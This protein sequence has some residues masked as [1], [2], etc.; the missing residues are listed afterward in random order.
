[1]KP[2]PAI[3]AINLPGL[4]KQGPQPRYKFT[5]KT[6]CECVLLRRPPRQSNLRAMATLDGSSRIPSDCLTQ[7]GPSTRQAGV[8]AMETVISARARSVA[9]N[10]RSRRLTTGPLR[11]LQSSGRGGRLSAD[12]AHRQ[13][14]ECP[15]YCRQ[16][17]RTS[18]GGC[19]AWSRAR[20]SV[21]VQCPQYHP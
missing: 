6:G 15:P 13:Q 9:R 8:S 16:R 21:P 20:C 11:R 1:M 19:S 18:S 5:E 7:S 14:S 2:D 12:K 17:Q 10:C 4:R 3:H